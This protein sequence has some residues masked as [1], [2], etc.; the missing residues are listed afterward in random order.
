M[1]VAAVAA[2]LRCT[3]TTKNVEFW[4][5]RQP[6]VQQIAARRDRRNVAMTAAA[7]ALA[8]SLSLSAVALSLSVS[9]LS[10]TA[11]LSLSVDSCPCLICGSRTQPTATATVAARANFIYPDLISQL[12]SLSLSLAPS[13]LSLSHECAN[14][15]L[16]A[17]F[18]MPKPEASLAIACHQ[19]LFA[20]ATGCFLRLISGTNLMI[21]GSGCYGK[22]G[23]TGETRTE[24][25]RWKESKR[26]NA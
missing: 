7:A 20:C 22:N 24:R 8:G 2:L 21:D 14:Y 5:L 18:G 15:F 1:G 16:L 6:G 10:C 4:R 9:L 19:L 12:R 13:V 17:R 26:E 23:T 3:H 11:T 25:E